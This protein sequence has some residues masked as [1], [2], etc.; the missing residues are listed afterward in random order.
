MG[1]LLA[2]HF[3][4]QIIT[5]VELI[6]CCDDETLRTAMELNRVN[7]LPSALGLRSVLAC[8]LQ[9]IANYLRH[10]WFA[11]RPGP[12][13]PRLSKLLLQCDDEIVKKNV[14]EVRWP[15]G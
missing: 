13:L 14:A 2:F 10:I 4:Q 12:T 11:L 1:H 8:K 7:T 9:S 6:F 5:N 15:R 3:H